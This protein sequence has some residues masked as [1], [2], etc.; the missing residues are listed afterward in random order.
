MYLQDIL[1]LDFAY[2]DT[3]TTRT[4]T[5]W[6]SLFCNENQPQYFDANH[7]LVSHSVHEPQAVINEVVMYYQAKGIIPRFYLYNLDLQKELIALLKANKFRFEELISPVQ[8]WNKK[9]FEKAVP[10]S[11]TIEF[12]TEKN[13]SEALAIECSIKEFGGRVVREKAFEQEFHHP[14]FQYY[15]LRY[16][17]MA[18]A[19]ACLFA[20]ERQA[21]IESVAT[22]EEF[23]GRGLI[24]FLIQYI[25]REA[26]KLGLENIWIFPINEKIERVYQKYGFTTVGKIK[27]GHA[28]LGGKS[29]TE[30]QA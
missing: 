30:I 24:G 14:K 18:C 21:R 17:D 20:D 29:I 26:A 11:V 12:V 7:A 3:F 22:L 2:L 13:Y 15:L 25:Q 5:N 19:T 16:N 6:G 28:F 1:A 8:L 23:R 10:E 4:D 27:M 9:I